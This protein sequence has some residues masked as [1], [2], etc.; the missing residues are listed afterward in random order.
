M[1]ISVVC[2]AGYMDEG[3]YFLWSLFNLYND[4]HSSVICAEL[5]SN[6]KYLYFLI[7]VK[8]KQFLSVKYKY[9]FYF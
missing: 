4:H 7:L 5:F 2:K 3:V 1:N 9:F 8:L 6:T